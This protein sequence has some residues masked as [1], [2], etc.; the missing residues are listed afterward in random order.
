M[1]TQYSHYASCAFKWYFRNQENPKFYSDAVKNNWNAC[2]RV[3]K[4]Y[5]DESARKIMEKVYLSND[6]V[7]DAVYETAKALEIPQDSVWT[8]LS[9]SEKKFAR[10]RG[11][12]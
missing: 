6:T 11:L 2:D 9:A 7:G 5:G 4:E 3:V 1:I 12:I 8:I 10:I